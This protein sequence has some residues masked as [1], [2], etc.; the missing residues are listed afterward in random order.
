VRTAIEAG[1]RIT[2]ESEGTNNF[3][4]GAH[5]FI[6]RKTSDGVVVN[7]AEAV[8]RNTA[9][10]MFTSWSAW[11]IFREDKLGSL[12]PGKFADYMVLNKDYFAVPVD[13]IKTIYPLMTVLQGKILMLR[14]EF[15]K[16][17]GRSPIG[18]QR[19]WNAPQGGGFG[20][21]GGF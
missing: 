17:L 20:G 7:A 9:L 2:Q 4:V 12:E 6:T 21:G 16:D 15:A 3:F 1:V 14:E 11:S 5:N 19:D 13:E 8:D 18:P 10:K